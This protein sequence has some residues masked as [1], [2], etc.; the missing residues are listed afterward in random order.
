MLPMTLAYGGLNSVSYIIQTS[1]GSGDQSLPLQVDTGSS[2]LWVASTSCTSSTCGATNG[3]LYNPNSSEGTGVD[4]N[5]SYLVGKATGVIVWDQVTLGGYQV[6]NQAL[7]VVSNVVNEPLNEFSGVLGLALPQ[8]SVISRAIPPATGDT[9]DGAIFTSNLLTIG[10]GAPASRFISLSLERPGSNR[11][12]SMFGIGRH[13]SSIISDPSKITY[14][15][16]YYDGQYPLFWKTTINAIT[17]YVN[18]VRKDVK[19]TSSFPGSVPTAILDTGVPVILA[20]TAI[21][22]GIYG[23][24]GIGP[25]ADGNFYVPCTT[26]LN[27]SIIVNGLSVPL[28]PLD[29]TQSNG[30][31]SDSCI[32]LIQDANAALTQS[33]IGDL[34]LGVPFMR[35]VYTVLAFTPPNSNGTYVPLSGTN[36]IID[37]RLGLLNLTDP[38]IAMEEF[39]DVR[40]LGQPLSGPG[41]KTTVSTSHHG[42]SVGIK[43]LIGLASGF[44]IL[45]A[46]FLAWYLCVRRR[47]KKNN[48]KTNDT[49]SGKGKGE[50]EL[51]TLEGKVTKEISPES[52]P[53]QMDAEELKMK[54]MTSLWNTVDSVRTKVDG[55]DEGNEE[56][57]MDEFGLV[58]FG[59]RTYHSS[60]S[61]G[62]RDTLVWD[63]ST[64]RNST[65][66][67]AAPTLDNGVLHSV[68]PNGAAQ[69][70]D[71]TL[72]TQHENEGDIGSHS[73][74]VEFPRM[75]DDT[76]NT[77]QQR[78]SMAGIGTRQF[79]R[80]TNDNFS[81]TETTR[82]SNHGLILFPPMQHA[83][84]AEEDLPRSGLDTEDDTADTKTPP[85]IDGAPP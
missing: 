63:E 19:L 38:A 50:L 83:H 84:S 11:I 13:P 17:V 74:I 65:R 71:H 20:T 28:H 69:A 2:D 21:A 29:L 44:G 64:F 58:Y 55:E 70:P 67:T 16:L 22:N 78:D 36:S 15:R 40:V 5:I 25:A 14:S 53:G 12:P 61:S 73:L 8:N 4:F 82:L 46:V 32:G 47:W 48:N 6:D 7:G 52:M 26:P 80:L 10:N 34:V 62:R 79:R 24:L 45:I 9:P 31:G 66:S 33:N 23:S 35:S 41:S 60:Q 49:S 59:R 72:T 27:M 56:M 1:F 42:L 3:K 37:P 57:L 39:Y 75:G 30:Q 77:D 18:G 43:V 85:W 54:R 68:T 81:I 76:Q 51:T